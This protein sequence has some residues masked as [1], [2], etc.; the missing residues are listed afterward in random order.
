M[1]IEN[2]RNVIMDARKLLV[3]GGIMVFQESDSMGAILY[4]GFPLH[5][6]VQ[7]WIWK[8]VEKEGGN[9][10][11]GSGL[12]SLLKGCSMK[13]TEYSSEN[14]LQTSETGS[15][16]SWVIKMMMGRVTGH[17]IATE[18]EIGEDTLEERLNGEILKVK[19]P[20]IRDV[21]FGIAGIKE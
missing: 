16:L 5:E 21:V 12:Y 10:H 1:Y 17:G 20:F 18:E 2:P 4:T 15:D 3:S 9:I 6:K 19:K 8:T 13:I 11:M 7:G 14:I